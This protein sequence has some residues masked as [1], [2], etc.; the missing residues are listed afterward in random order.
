M[1]EDRCDRGQEL[2][3]AIRRLETA[4]PV[5]HPSWHGYVEEMRACL[6]SLASALEVAAGVPEVLE[7][8]ARALD[9]E[10]EE[11]FDAHG[12]PSAL[13][14]AYQGLG[15]LPIPAGEHPYLDEIVATLE[16]LE[17]LLVSVSLVPAAARA[18]A[19]DAA[20]DRQPRNNG[21]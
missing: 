11:A 14:A 19:E 3:E 18:F 6:G 13:A 12:A 16:A 9:G 7:L 15:R 2:L 1:D 5:P 8:V 4:F 17:A 10:L 21:L 20:T